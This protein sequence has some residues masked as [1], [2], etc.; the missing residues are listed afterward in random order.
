MKRQS[1]LAPSV[2]LLAISIQAKADLYNVVDLGTIPGCTQTRAYS[3][4]NAGQVVGYGYGPSVAGRAILFDSTGAGNAVPLHGGGSPSFAYSINDH[5]DIAGRVGGEIVLWGE[6]SMSLAAGY[7]AYSVN[8]SLQVVGQRSDGAVL[9]DASGAGNHIRLGSGEATSINNLGQIVGHQCSGS[10]EATLFDPTGQG[11]NIA[12]GG[13][14]G[15]S[16]SFAYAISDSGQAVGSVWYGGSPYKGSAVLFDM[17]GGGNNIDLGLL[18][19]ST[20]AT[21]AFAINN[22]GQV[23]GWQI[24]SPGKA[25]LFDPTGAGNN[26]DLNSLIDSALGWNLWQARSINDNGWIAGIGSHGGYESAFLLVPVS[27]PVPIPV[28]GAL[29]LGSLGLSY[30]GWR[31]RR[32]RT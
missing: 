24:G 4:N 16:D 14:P 27:E 12:L 20:D 13:L 26:I 11:N 5:G 22:S 1:V 15:Y 7:D 9:F 3:V 21:A 8:N 2:I 10:Y 18:S 6:H 17:T 23:V 29:V 25:I 31:L 19:G 32:R 28:P 30:S